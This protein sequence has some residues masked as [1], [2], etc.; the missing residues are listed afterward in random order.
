MNLKKTK[1][2]GVFILEPTVFKDS[3]G[4]FLESY[5]EQKFLQLGIK[6]RF[7]QDNEAKSNYGVIR[8]LHYQ[9]GEFSQAKLV[10][11]TQGKVLDVILDLRKNS[12]TYGRCISIPISALN[13]KQVLIPRGCAHGYS[14]LSKSAVFNYKC[15]NFYSPQ[16]EG[17]IH[18]LDPILNIDWK[19][20]TDSR[21]ISEKDLHWPNF[22]K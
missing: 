17:G 4:Y 10:R 11:V 12:K 3:R 13:R 5:N 16:N 18:P 2:E 20:K 6:N 21:I 7:V 8:G 19:V 14:V 15:D 22:E 1:I 9:A